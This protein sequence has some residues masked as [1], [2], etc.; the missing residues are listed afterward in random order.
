MLKCGLFNDVL[1]LS[2]HYTAHSWFLHLYC[3]FMD[4]RK[5]QL[6]M[7]AG[8]SNQQRWKTGRRCDVVVIHKDDILRQLVALAFKLSSKERK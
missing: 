4:I 3:A 6:Q 1:E 5:V 7:T 2:L 8:P